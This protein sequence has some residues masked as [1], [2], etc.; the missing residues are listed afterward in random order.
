MI[1]RLDFHNS[2]QNS[3]EEVSKKPRPL[4]VINFTWVKTES[5][6]C[7]I[8]SLSFS[9]PSS[10]YTNAN[11]DIWTHDNPNVSTGA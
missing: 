2:R 9:V 8:N 7:R 6:N 10:L 3:L 1:E 11:P 4:I 5:A